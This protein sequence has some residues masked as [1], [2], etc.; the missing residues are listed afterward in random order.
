MNALTPPN[1][2]RIKIALWLFVTAGA[3]FT[4]MIIGAITRLT[5]SGLSMVEWKPLIGAI[6]PLNQ[7]QWQHVFDLYKQ[8]PEFQQKNFWMELP[9]FKE[10]FFWEWLHRLWGR[11]IGM[12][13][14]LPLLY[15]WLRGM[16]PRGYGV[17][18]LCILFLGGLQGALGWYMVKSGLIAIPAVSHY[19]LAAH[20]GLA[21][22]IFMALLWTGLC[23]VSIH[24]RHRANAALFYHGLAVLGI[25]LMTIAWGAFTA[26][27]DAGLIYNEFPLMGG[28]W[29]PPDLW[30]IKPAW[31]NF[32]ENPAAVQFT[33]RC[34]AYGLFLMVLGW[35]GHAAARRKIFPALIALGVMILLQ[36]AL[37]I[38]TVL[39]GAPLILASLHQGGAMMLVLLMVLALFQLRPR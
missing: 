29:A 10:I 17:P 27:L 9:D 15:F 39:N 38:A 21:L 18:L 35:L 7:A 37:G 11:L 33:H 6:P 5:E 14:A 16:I 34:L 28:Q 4:M 20:L 1:S 3:V 2:H 13:Y 8:T 30:H 31:L 24:I 19:R 25:T 36:L 12:I 22:L 26:G 32:F 23:L